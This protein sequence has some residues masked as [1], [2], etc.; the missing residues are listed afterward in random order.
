MISLMAK[1]M[2]VIPRSDIR[3]YSSFG[4]AEVHRSDEIS[5]HWTGSPTFGAGLNYNLN[6]HIMAELGANYTAGKGQSEL[7]PVDDYF[8]F[9]YSVF[10]RLAYRL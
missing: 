4:F 2:M 8:P 1:I 5:D 6:K 10:L 9:V 7:S 3:I